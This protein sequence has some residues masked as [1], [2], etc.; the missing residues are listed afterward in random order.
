MPA[1][2]GGRARVGEAHPWR[3]RTGGSGVTDGSR[4]LPQA[5]PDLTGLMA[6]LAERNLLRG[7][8]LGLP[9]GQAMAR[10]FG[11][12]PLTSSEILQGLPDAEADALKAGGQM[13]LRRTPLWY[14]VLREAAAL[15]NG[16]QLGP[17]GGRIVAETFLR[18][19]RRDPDSYLTMSGGF[20]PFLPSASP[21]D[22]TFTDLI[23]F[24]G[25]NLP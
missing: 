19:L 17:V 2:D 7:L 24:S 1:P 6:R 3:T 10:S 20:A 13:L 9:S 21:G 8:A 18:M 14:Y 16:E 4:R 25:V 22:F 5:L 15:G 23:Q 12:T 11:I